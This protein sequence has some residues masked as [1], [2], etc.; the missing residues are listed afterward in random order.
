MENSKA[1]D[2]Q[3]L[4]PAEIKT[5]DFKRIMWGYSPE[6][7]VSFLEMTAKAWEKVQ[8]QER[9][10]QL[11]IQAMGDELIQW[12]GREGELVKLREKALAEAE[13]IRQKATEDAT[14]IYLEMEERAAQ[15]RQRTEEWLTTVI[16]QVEATERQKHSFVTAFRTALESHY[17]LLNREQ[18][19]SAPLGTQLSQFLKEAMAP[20]LPS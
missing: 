4:T 20:S 16:E 5:R 7:V 3:K 17:E 2:P 12:K 1:L 10:L 8:K 11:K 6:E 18:N 13:G 15:I 9:D 14:K 19:E